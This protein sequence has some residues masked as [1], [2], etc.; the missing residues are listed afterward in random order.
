MAF[1]R[2]RRDAVRT[3]LRQGNARSDTD[4]GTR[5]VRYASGRQGQT[6]EEGGDSGLRPH[7]RFQN[8]QFRRRTEPRAKQPD[9]EA[10]EDDAVLA[11]KA[12]VTESARTHSYYSSSVLSGKNSY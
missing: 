7:S 11:E 9:G 1:S 4:A 10:V 6:K 2:S 12:A 8:P 3:S 5:G